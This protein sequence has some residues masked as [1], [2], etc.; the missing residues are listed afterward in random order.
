MVKT[1][2]NYIYEK[3]ATQNCVFSR[4]FRSRKSIRYLYRKTVLNVIANYF[5]GKV[6]I[7]IIEFRRFEL[8][9]KRPNIRDWKISRLRH[10]F[11]R[12]HVVLYDNYKVFWIFFF[13]LDVCTEKSLFTLV[14][15][16][17]TGRSVSLFNYR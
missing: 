14:E 2:L 8:M 10:G 3:L 16:Y 9:I 15:Y 4:S 13:L 6:C 7:A 12:K 17:L 5:F 11:L 1:Y